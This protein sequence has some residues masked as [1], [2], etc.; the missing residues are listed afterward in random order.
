MVVLVGG[1]S[2]INGAIPSSLGQTVEKAQGCLEKNSS[3]GPEGNQTVLSGSAPKDS[4]IT[5]STSCG[6]FIPD[7]PKAFPLFVRLWGLR[8]EEDAA[9]CLT[10]IAR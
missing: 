4:L 10:K 1:G 2:V 3:G 7:N 9:A 5:L 6:K 8:T